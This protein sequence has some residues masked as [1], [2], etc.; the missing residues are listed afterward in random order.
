[1]GD[2]IGHEL[3]RAQSLV[4]IEAVASISSAG[5]LIARHKYWGLEALFCS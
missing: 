1:M 2:A 4:R 3:C 5:Q